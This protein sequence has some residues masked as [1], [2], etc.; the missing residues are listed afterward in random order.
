MDS[1]FPADQETEQL[2]S[3]MFKSRTKCRIPYWRDVVFAASKPL[4][5][6]TSFHV[7]RMSDARIPNNCYAANY[8][9]PN[10]TLEAS[11]RRDTKTSW[12]K[13]SDISVTRNGKIL[14]QTCPHGGRSTVLHCSEAIRRGAYWRHIQVCRLSS[15]KKRSSLHRHI[16]HNHTLRISVEWT[17]VYVELSAEYELVIYIN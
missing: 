4:Y 6:V 12:V 7:S 10:D 14:Q 5:S 8:R 3:R 1:V 9:T 2:S 11:E 13:A 15:G 16:H 17:H